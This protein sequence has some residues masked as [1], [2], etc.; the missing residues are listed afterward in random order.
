MGANIIVSE[1]TTRILMN[2]N[3]FAKFIGKSGATI[4]HIRTSS[5]ATVRGT[6]I[7]NE[8]RIV[9]ISGTPRQ[10][11][12]AFDLIADTMYQAHLAAHQSGF[13]LQRSEGSDQFI[14]NVLVD[15]NKAGRIVGPK[16]ATILSLKN[17]SGA[18]NIRMQKEPQTYLDQQ[19][20]LISL[21]GTSHSI[22]RAHYNLHE[23]CL[24]S[25]Y[26]PTFH[27]HLQHGRSLHTAPAIYHHDA[28]G[29]LM[30]SRD[31]SST[32]HYSHLQADR[33]KAMNVDPTIIRQ[34]SE[35]SEYLKNN[36]GLIVS[37]TPINEIPVP[38]GYGAGGSLG[39]SSHGGA[40]AHP[41]LYDSSHAFSPSAGQGPRVQG[42]DEIIFSVPRAAAGG[43]I[44]KGGH[45]L[46]DLMAEFGLKIYLEKEATAD[47]CRVVVL[48]L[49]SSI[50]GGPVVPLTEDQIEVM[51]T[52]KERILALRDE[53]LLL[54]ARGTD[55]SV[56]AGSSNGNN[57][58]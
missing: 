13:Y 42:V 34:L 16:G 35:M 51:N 10:V 21:E 22:M 43:I 30:V 26:L 18:T 17:K 4:A 49:G 40:H 27:A 47:G 53:A 39:Y 58:E 50:V 57:E 6:D 28:S 44:G 3:E 36:F 1:L 9:V 46:K 29:N 7:D 33:L 24:D 32:S 48:K 37:V 45:V 56:G 23:L 8:L 38:G 20:R 11:F 52:C 54:D 25:S 19:L 2:K 31:A 41:H 15:H 5:G 55:E 12:D 14:I